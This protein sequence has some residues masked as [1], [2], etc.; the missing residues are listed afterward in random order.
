MDFAPKFWLSIFTIVLVIW[1]W[2]KE[3]R[4]DYLWVFLTGTAIWT[5]AEAALQVSGARVMPARDLYGVMLPLPIS[6][7]LQGI[8]E[9]AFVAVFSLFV[10]D[11]LRDKQTR[12]LALS[13]FFIMVL[14]LLLGTIFHSAELPVP[15]SPPSRRNILAPRALVFLFC[16]TLFNII[17][18]IK[19][20]TYRRRT[21]TMSVVMLAFVTLWS[22]QQVYVGERWVETYNTLTGAY[23]KASFSAS[24]STL[25][26][27]I[28]FEM[29]MAYIPFFA[30][31]VMLGWI[32]NRPQY[33]GVG[34]GET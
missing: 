11:C 32:K 4:L 21:L 34:E 3:K 10:G 14:V 22:L 19:Y 13:L 29:L 20:K 24:V 9:G 6:A 5:L 15:E 33:G 16:M 1:D 7:F 30:I 12:T 25:S 27:D 18:W 8:A 28:V 23:T 17:F 31:P 2:S 26:F